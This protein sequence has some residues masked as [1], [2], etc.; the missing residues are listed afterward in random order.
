MNWKEKIA[1]KL[2]NSRLSGIER[3]KKITSLEKAQEIGILW[4]I[5]DAEAYHYL[6]EFLKN[7]QAVVRKLCFTGKKGILNEHSGTFSNKD[8]DW[9]GFPVS[10][11]VKQFIEFRFDILMNISTV[12]NFT[13]DAIVAL[14]KAN[15]KIGWSPPPKNYLDLNID[16]KKNIDSLFLVKQQ[17]FYLGQLNKKFRK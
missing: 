10:E 16:I 15:F 9:F 2:L 13:F 11:N 5:D 1:Y 17:I 6:S 4:H 12:R 7:K 14:S 3:N 8:L